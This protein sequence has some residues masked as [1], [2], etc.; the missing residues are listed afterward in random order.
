MAAGASGARCW[1]QSQMRSYSEE[2][3]KLDHASPLHF[4]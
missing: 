4:V 3:R 2:S 1:D